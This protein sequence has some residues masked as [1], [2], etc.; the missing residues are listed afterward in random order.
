MVSGSGFVPNETVKLSI[1]GMSGVTVTAKADAKG[2]LAPTGITIPYSLKPGSYTVTAN[3]VSSKR[4][5]NT[6]IKV[7]ALTPSISISNPSTAPGATETVNGKG[8]GAKEQ[9]TLSLNGEALVTTPSVI[10]TTNGAFSATF[11]VPKSVLNGANSISAIGNE[12]RVNAVTSL[13]GNL[14]QTAQFYFAGAIN[15]SRDHSY[16]SL[17]NTH[18]EPVRVHLS[19]YF[20]TGATYTADVTVNA[21]SQKRVSVASLGNYPEG[22]YGLVVKSDRPIAAQI[23]TERDGMDGDVMLGNS[24]PDT[25]WYLAAGATNSSFQENASIFNPDL[26]TPTGVQLQLVTAAGK[27]GKTVMVTIPAHTNYVANVNKLFPN[28]SSVGVVAISSRPVVVERTLTFGP[29]GEGLTMRSGSNKPSTNWLFADSTTENNVQTI[30]SVLNPSDHG[31]LVTASFSQGNGVVLGS[32]SVY[33]PARSRTTIN[34]ADIVHGGGIAAVVTSD[35][36]VVVERSEYIGSSDKAMAGSDV[37]G[38]NGAATR[39]SFPGGNTTPGRNEV[40]DLYN[41]S[42]VTVPVTAT[43][44]MTDGKM[45][46]RQ[47]TL[48]PTARIIIPINTLASTTLHGE[49]LQSGSTQGFIAEQGISAKDSHLLRATQGLAQ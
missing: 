31:A 36:A 5:A 46:I 19:F 4:S 25:H 27:M 41:P 9:V 11:T 42:A 44:Y 49:V 21:T 26:A 17:L 29:N 15:T 6:T 14:T 18:K 34:L 48:A 38:R 8:F 3:G 43:L 12:S 13:T 16:I 32:R 47:Y 22:T 10:T 23:A 7:A 45:I 33:V 20:N 1:N 2:M 40:L 37:F 24:A 39:W 30:Y 28:Q 35:Q